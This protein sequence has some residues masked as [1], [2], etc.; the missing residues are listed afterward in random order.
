MSNQSIAELEKLAVQALDHGN[1]FEAV[2]YFR[3]CIEQS[4][5]FS[6]RSYFLRWIA[7]TQEA[8]GRF[9]EARS[10]L[11]IAR[12]IDPT[13]WTEIAIGHLSSRRRDS[14]GVRRCLE[15]VRLKHRDMLASDSYASNALKQELNE[16][17]RSFN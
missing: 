6:E 9:D 8:E 2:K 17:E 11:E 7:R 13:P 16:L 14:N 3:I 5:S 12:T 15:A 1:L 4:T 10:T